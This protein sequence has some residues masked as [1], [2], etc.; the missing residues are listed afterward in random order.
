MTIDVLEI[1]ALNAF[2][3][4]ISATMVRLVVLPAVN[5]STH[6]LWRLTLGRTSYTHASTWWSICMEQ[7]PSTRHRTAR[8][9]ILKSWMR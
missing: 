5:V 7:Q 4:K 9:S 2:H 6:A 3:V 1:Q 8:Y